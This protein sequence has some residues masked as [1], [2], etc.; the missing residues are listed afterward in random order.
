VHHWINIEGNN[1]PA[2]N[3]FGIILGMVSPNTSPD[4]IVPGDG[5]AEV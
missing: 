1:V 2:F 4:I 3:V 5:L